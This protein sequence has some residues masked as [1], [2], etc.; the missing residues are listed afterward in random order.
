MQPE[1]AR[2]KPARLDRILHFT[3]V[4]LIPISMVIASV[5]AV[6]LL[7]KMYPQVSG[8]PVTLR[9][10]PTSEKV[11]L[12]PETAYSTLRQ[13]P[14]SPSA[15]SGRQ[16]WMLAD[17]PKQTDFDDYLLEIPSRH[18]T[19][20]ICWDANTMD[21]IGAAS[22]RTSA[23]DI[24]MAKL[25][26]NITMGQL[27]R[28][29]QTLCYGTFTQS[30]HVSA[31]LW[32]VNQ[33][34][35]A[36]SRFDHG[37]GLLEGGL[38][39]PALFA[40]LIAIIAGQST[41]AV[42]AAWLIANLRLGAFAIGWDTQWLGFLLPLEA[43]PYIR[44]LT[45]AAYYLLTVTLLIRLL[46][47]SNYTKHPRLLKLTKASAILLMFASV[48]PN[49][50]FWSGAGV[51][52]IFGM[53]AAIFLL[54][55][56]IKQ[57]GLAIWFW[58]VTSLA[59][60]FSIIIGLAV[61]LIFG[62]INDLDSLNTTVLLLVSSAAMVLSLAERLRNAGS[63]QQ[64]LHTELVTSYAITPIGMFTLDAQ[65]RFI[66][67]NPVLERMLGFTIAQHPDARWAD[68]F[69]ELDWDELTS[70]AHANEDVEIT[71]KK[72]HSSDK[73]QHF[74]IRAVVVNKTIEGSLQDISAHTAVIEQLRI[75]AGKDPV[76]EALNQRSFEEAVANAIKT[77]ETTGP[78]SLVYLSVGHFKNINSL[79]GYTTGD[80]LLIQ[81]R[82][83]I[84]ATL[85]QPYEIGRVGSDEFAILFPGKSAEQ[86]EPVVQDLAHGINNHLFTIAAHTINVKV[87]MG[88]IDLSPELNNAKEALFAAGRACGDAHKDQRTVVTYERGSA[89]LSEHR[90]LL[91][92][93][94]QIEAGKT[95]EGFRLYLQPMLSFHSPK[96][97]SSFEVLL[98]VNDS[99]NRP[100]SAGRVIA[101]AE[102]IGTITTIDKWVLEAILSWLN[103]NHHRLPSLRLLSI[104]ISGVSLNSDAFIEHL[105][106]LLDRYKHLSRYLLIEM[107]EGVALQDLERTQK[108]IR[109][110]QEQGV[111]I[112]LDDF[113]AGY[114]SFSYLRNLNA[115]V[116]KIDGTLIQNMLAD[117][118]NIAI[119]RTIIQLAHQLKM[120]CIAEWVED[121]ATLETLHKMGVD[122]VQGFYISPAVPLATVLKSKS[123]ID[124][125]STN[126]SRDSVQL[127][128][129][130]QQTPHQP[131]K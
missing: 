22:R 52:A 1:P 12:D 73:T 10:L 25:G 87:A 97:A 23:P 85:T 131:S 128:L 32:S 14:P 65:Q 118:N 24:R 92:L 113:G 103:E 123:I 90:E 30:H 20:L 47:A 105:F 48:L 57:T 9:I 72:R 58:Q 122:Y 67:M 26:F 106:R 46:R 55:R 129:D 69:P 130:K 126:E 77:L 124:F 38:L 63:E 31:R 88:L 11:A 91:H 42:L 119:V 96:D 4:Y 109:R 28:P 62:N 49:T 108:T 99:E 102:D 50:W 3:A 89:A 66:R 93:F 29:Q 112:G 101:A 59:L 40:L 19:S 60:A 15:S 71:A 79:F 53:I 35:Q 107:T 100:L 121:K 43:M 120:K 68:Y 70:K 41:Y 39:T 81:T 110:I 104:N 75:L 36:S 37:M 84:T 56:V 111:R 64:R 98:R 13:Q 18:V 21:V 86:I 5:L 33:F 74:A 94:D 115:D 45:A 125:L 16:A 51:I 117:A 114:T 6:L 83:K 61:L 78:A 80:A 34:H 76:T 7:D 8:S 116:I 2:Q 95:P 17:I 54:T 44:Q 27:V 82:K 127:I